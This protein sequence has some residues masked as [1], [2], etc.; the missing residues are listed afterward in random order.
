MKLPCVYIVGAG[1]GDPS[2]ISVRGQRCLEAADVVVYDHRVHARLLRRARADVE[3][4]DVGAAAPRPFDQDA[5]SLLLAEKAREGKA[6]VRLK[7]GDPFVFDS[8]G[9][10]ALFLHEQGIPFEVVPGIPVAIAGPAYAGIPVTYPEAGDVLV[11]VRG[12]ENESD[13]LEVDDW[14]RLA[15]LKGTLVC[16]AGARQI[17]SATRALLQH[18]RAGDE[19]AALIYD[20]SLP[21]QR[22]VDA[23]LATIADKADPSTPALLVVGAVAGFRSHLR[24][25]DNR[26]L[27]GLRI[28]VTRSREQAGDL[29]DMLEERGA[30]AIGAPSISILPPVDSSALDA[31]CAQAASFDWIVFTSANAVD[32][33]MGRLLTAGDVRDLHGV[34]LCTVGPSTASR[35]QKYGIRVDLTP[36]EFR[37]EAIA[38]AL[39][40]RGDLNGKRLLL[41]RADLARD[42]LGDELR[43][44]GADVVEVIAYR[45]VPE[46][47]E[48]GTEHDIYRMLLDRQIDAVTFA[49]ASAVRNFVELLG[50]DQAADLLRD[51]VVASIGPVTAEAGRHLGLV[52]TVMPERHTIPDLV[53]ALVGYFSMREPNLT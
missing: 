22:T 6:V 50:K 51:V 16:Y 18:G 8:G 29:I 10:E 38:D 20:A 14:G 11:F 25:F 7:W 49:S 33:F 2:L 15:G 23:T 36:G 40:A 46:T 4:I 1:P 30:E 34:Q 35:L 24:W 41:P 45:T 12:H 53:D 19:T 28:V 39:R 5:I 3:R 9:K 13:A 43:Q 17:A 48:R 52:T 42:R 44:S 26:P 27:S 37:A 32:R 47:A 31:A 21:S